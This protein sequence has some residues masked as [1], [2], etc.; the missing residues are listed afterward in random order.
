MNLAGNNLVKIYGKRYVVDD[1][2]VKVNTGEVVGLLGPNGAG[3]TTTFY[4]IMGAVRP[5]AGRVLLDEENLTGL[6]MH[7]R[8]LRGLGYLAQEPSIFKKLSVEDNLRIVLELQ[9]LTRK[10]QDEIIAARLEEFHISHL[11]DQMGF[12]LSGGER[13]RVEIAR[14]LCIEPKFILLDEPFTGVDP[15]AINDIQDI[16]LHLKARGIGVLLTDHNVRETFQITDRSYIINDGKI[17]TEGTPAD[18]VNDPIA[19]KFY[20]GERFTA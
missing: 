2:S 11:K 19:R 9:R 6:P 14:T 18:L 8:A 7:R 17:L 3:K 10:Q 13:R 5:N 15:I 16:I 12:A 4:M 20:L 1:L